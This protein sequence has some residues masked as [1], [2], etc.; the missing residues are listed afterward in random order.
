MKLA[1]TITATSNDSKASVSVQNN[2]LAA[3]KTTPVSVVVTA[4]NGTTK[5]YVINV[6]RAQDP[7]YVP[8]SNN[9]L[10][11]IATSYGSLSPTFDKNVTHYAMNVPYECTSIAFTAAPEDPLSTCVVLGDSSLIAGTDNLFYGVVT[12]ENG[13]TRIYYITVRREQE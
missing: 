13:T 1:L 8:S 11:S 3:G 12:A 2:A 7:N 4:E 9:Y 10:A 6:A 5:A